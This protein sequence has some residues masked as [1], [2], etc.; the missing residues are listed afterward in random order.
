M[1]FFYDQKTMVN[2][3]LF[4]AN[5]AEE[6]LTGHQVQV[7]AYWLLIVIARALVLLFS[8]SSATTLP[9]SAWAMM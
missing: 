5:V 6:S 7:T 8:T 1:L 4:I 2:L 9:P 3:P